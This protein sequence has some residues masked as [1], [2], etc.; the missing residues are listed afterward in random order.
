MNNKKKKK[1]EVQ[2]EGSG[3]AELGALSRLGPQGQ[4]EQGQLGKEGKK[5]APSRGRVR[6]LKRDRLCPPSFT[7]L[8]RQSE[9][10]SHILLPSYAVTQA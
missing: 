4:D 7:A 6:R 5:G 1:E 9:S 10:G 2:R 3:Q 8:L